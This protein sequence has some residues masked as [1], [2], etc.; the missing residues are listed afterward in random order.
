MVEQPGWTLVVALVGLLTLA[1]IGSQLGGLHR[2]R[3]V[4]TAAVRAAVQLAAVSL[5]IAAVLSNLVW[6]V[7]FG[8]FMVGV[9]TVTSSR[10]IG[11]PRRWPYVGLAIV[12]GVL[13]TLS[14][15][16]ASGAV[17][18]T[19]ASIVPV[20]GII[21]GG[22]MTAG[23]LS[24]R[25]VFAAIRDGRGEL[26]AGLSLGLPRSQAVDEVIGRHLPRSVDAGTRPD[27]NCRSGDPSRPGELPLGQSARSWACCSAAGHLCKPARPSFWC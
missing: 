2:E 19:G 13:P 12:T 20:A 25:R 11:A 3:Q 26:E 4:V 6:S 18:L 7:L 10:R 1:I 5:I 14:V 8:T 16:F 24:G 9:A 27:S 21:I 17:P 22:A 23:S 15:I